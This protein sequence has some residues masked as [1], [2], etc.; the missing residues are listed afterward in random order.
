MNEVKIVLYT[1]LNN[2]CGAAALAYINHDYS[3]NNESHQIDF[4]NQ[5]FDNPSYNSD[6][7]E[8]QN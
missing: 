8:Q 6:F 5:E 1:M 2:A 4:T 3:E 7:L